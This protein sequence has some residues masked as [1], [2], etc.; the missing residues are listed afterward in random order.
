MVNTIYGISKYVHFILIKINN[1]TTVN[2]IRKLTSC[3][4]TVFFHNNGIIL[5]YC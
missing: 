5:G 3:R 1:I 4:W 2:W